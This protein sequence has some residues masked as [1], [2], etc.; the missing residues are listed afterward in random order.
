[1]YTYTEYLMYL[2]L[3]YTHLILPHHQKRTKAVKKVTLYTTHMYYTYM[4]IVLVL[5][6]I[7]LIT[8]INYLNLYIYM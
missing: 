5:L 6:L 2:S 1:M 4:Y 3:V 8:I 7:I